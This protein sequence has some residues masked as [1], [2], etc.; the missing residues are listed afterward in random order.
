[1]KQ[2]FL[3]KK[4]SQ[5]SFPFKFGSNKKRI[6]RKQR[7]FR[8]FFYAYKQIKPLFFENL[9]ERR[10]F[11][12]TLTLRKRKTRKKLFFFNKRKVRLFLFK[13]SQARSLNLFSFVSRLSFRRF[14]FF[15]WR[16]YYLVRRLRKKVARKFSFKNRFIKLN[17][18][19]N[20]EQRKSL[21]KKVL[22]QYKQRM[23]KFMLGNELLLRYS[24]F[25]NLKAPFVGTFNIWSFFKFGFKN[26]KIGFAGLFSSVA[27]ACICYTCRF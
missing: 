9:L 4:N 14:G 21:Q 10:W 25:N 22:K 12:S 23:L 15:R 13:K 1:M 26:N 18:N 7:K 20:I 6:A 5:K 17:Y 19:K 2:V 3:E 16:R 11:F 24:F 8:R 27:Y